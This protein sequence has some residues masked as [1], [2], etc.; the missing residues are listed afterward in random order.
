MITILVIL[1]IIGYVMIALEHPIKINKAATALILGMVLWTI[2]S[3][4]LGNVDA[5]NNSVLEHMG[6]ITEILFFLIGAMT[7]VEMVDVHGGFSIVTDHINTHSK[8]KLLWVLG[9]ITFL[10]SSVLDNLTTAIVITM[11]LRKLVSDQHERWLYAAIIIIAANAGGAWSPIGD[12]T[13]IM[14]W[15]KGNVTT[16]ALCSFVFLPSVISL[17]IPLICITPMLKGQLVSTKG[18]AANIPLAGDVK[19]SEKQ[20]LFYMGVGGLLFVPIFKGITGLPPFMGMMISLSVIWFYT[21][22]MY[23]KKKGEEMGEFRVPTVLKRID[24]QTILFFLGILLAVAALQEAGILGS[25]AH[26]LD[27]KLHNIYIIDIIL[28]ALSSIVDNV[29]LV[30]ASISMYP[31]HTAASIPAGPEYQYMMHF[32]QDGTFWEFL[33]YCVGVGGSIFIIGSAAGVVVMGLEKMNFIW[34]MK[35]ISLIALAGYLGGAAVYI[36]EVFLFKGV[37]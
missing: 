17:V 35:K 11:L 15:V 1:F 23:G 31:L 36:L 33:S 4:S 37:M 30:A 27:L 3:V 7:I 14:L 25:V 18:T 22:I 19:K 20:T 21:D 24:I 28:G 13:T 2:Y 6:D 26:W 12:V 8:K 5:I 16:Q 10:M 9:I 32:V 29:P 34:Y